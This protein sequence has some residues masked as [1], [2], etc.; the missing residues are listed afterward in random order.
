MPQEI[1][2]S[3]YWKKLSS[4][5]MKKLLEDEEMEGKSLFPS[6]S[7]EG[8]GHSLWHFITYKKQKRYV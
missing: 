5:L 3:L 6:I 7:A 2:V 4:I 1:L 8:H